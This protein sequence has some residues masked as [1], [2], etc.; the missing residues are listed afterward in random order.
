M[1]RAPV[2]GSFTHPSP[3]DP[4]V[5]R[6]ARLLREGGRRSLNGA[7]VALV[8][9]VILTI[10]VAL[11]VESG[12]RMYLGL[13]GV[14]FGEFCAGVGTAILGWLDRRAARRPGPDLADEQAEPAA[15]TG[16]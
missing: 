15:L 8:G 2:S 9:W 1:E 11:Y 10:G 12:H 7:G 13:A 3:E 4:E 16:S 5:L 6:R 14:G